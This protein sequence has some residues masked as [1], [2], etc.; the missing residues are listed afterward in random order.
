MGDHLSFLQ[1]EPLYMRRYLKILFQGDFHKSIKKEA[2]GS[3]ITTELF[4][5]IGSYWRWN[6]IKSECEYVKSVHNRFRD[7]I[8]PGKPLPPVYDKALGSIELLLVN[9]VIYRG[10]QFG[11]EM[12]HR[13]G[14]SHKWTFKWRPDC[15]PVEFQLQRKASAEVEQKILYEKDP[16]EWCLSQ[17]QAKPDTQTNYDHAIMFAFLE[18]HLASSSP[19]EKA[20]VDEILAQKLS[21]LAACHEMLVSVRLHRPQNV[22][23]DLDEVEVVENRIS[24]KGW[25]VSG[26]ITEEDM[27]RLGTALLDDF[28]KAPLPGSQKNMTW[29]HRSKALR[30]ALEA[31]WRGA[32]KTPKMVFEQS[33]FSTEEVRETL[34]VISCTL[35]REYL[36]FVEEEEQHMLASIEGSRVSAPGVSQKEW[37][38]KTP[39]QLTAVSPKSKVKS[40]PLKENTSVQQINDAI[41][42]I[43]I[44]NPPEKEKVYVKQRTHD[45]LALM[46]P[47]NAMES[48]KG[49]E[50][51]EFVYMM[52]SMGF[53]ARNVGGSAVVFENENESPEGASV[54][55]K[56]I[57]HKPHPVSKIDPIMLHSNGKRMSK[58]FGWHRDLFVLKA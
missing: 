15:G 12:P 7:S 24:W 6:W 25:K 14:F 57:F 21:D 9:E 30:R 50:W 32:R 27:L 13:P 17:M 33:G 39:T 38:S 26:Y 54:G 52:S 11:K 55:G 44:S 31:F 49:M 56:I 47:S 48:A 41:P 37:G 46:Y 18:N 5:D 3:M 42:G 45:L 19:M 2:K 36:D 20:R 28:Y 43:N 51:G 34:E 4:K 23:R 1:T 22:A 58:W 10:I 8:H 35:T 16:L 53:L 29:V 40:R